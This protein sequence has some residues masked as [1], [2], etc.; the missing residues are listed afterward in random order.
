MMSACPACCA[1]SARMC[2]NTRRA[3]QRAPGS[4]QGASG[5]GWS[6]SREG[7]LSMSR[8]VSAATASYSLSRPPSVSPGS[9]RKPSSYDEVRPASAKA[10]G[11]TSTKRRQVCSTA[12]TCLI[13]PPTQRV[14]TVVVRAACWS[15][16]PATVWR[17]KPRCLS[18]VV[19][20][21]VRSVL[22]GPSM[23]PYADSSCPLIGGI[24]GPGR[25]APVGQH[26]VGVVHAVDPLEG[27]QQRVQVGRVGQLE[28]E[29]HARHPVGTGERVAAQDVEVVVGDHLPHVDPEPGPVQS[30]EL[31]GGDE[32]SRAV[33]VPLHL[34][35]AAHVA[36]RQPRRVRAVA[37]VDAHAAA[38]CDEADDLVAGHRG[39]APAEADHHVVEALDVHPYGTAV[40][41]PPAGLA[42]GAGQLLLVL[43]APQL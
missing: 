13:S 34:H 3:D 30:L 14:L 16:R 24:A 20:R 23:A 38:A 35:H 26:P 42:G 8:L 10:W 33:P 31:D 6:P 21:S 27:G 40:A 15:S 1:V 2:M 22:M 37:A 43:A 19:I 12:A 4:N 29:A 41:H 5:S 17:R 36:R 7:R 28:L 25:L 39:A 32:A 11:P 18:R 9:I